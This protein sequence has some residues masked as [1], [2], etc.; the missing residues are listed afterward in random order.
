[1]RLIKGFI[2]A[3]AIFAVVV[4]LSALCEGLA[5]LF[6]MIP[7]RVSMWVFFVIPPVMLIGYIIEE[8][9][10]EAGKNQK[11]VH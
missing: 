4:A 8:V 2:G 11:D 1:M 5:S 3:G 9:R 10:Y 7:W 6:D